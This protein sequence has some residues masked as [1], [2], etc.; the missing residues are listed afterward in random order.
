M[1]NKEKTAVRDSYASNVDQFLNRIMVLHV[2][3]QNRIFD[4]FYERYLKAVEA[5][6][7]QGAFDFGMEEIR[8]RNLRRVA[9]GETLFVDPAS[10]ARTM[11]HELEGEVDVVRHT[12]AAA[13]SAGDQ[14][15]FRNKRSRRIYTVSK[16]WDAHRPE[17]FLTAVK[18]PRRTLEHPELEQKYER[19]EPVEAREWWEAEHAST[20]ATEPR[21]FYI[22]SGAI[23]PIYDKVMGSS[24]IQ[25]VKIARAVLADGQALVGLNL[26]AS[27]VPNVKQR[28]GIGTPLGEAS[29]AEIVDL[30]IGGAVIELDNGWQ[31]TSAGIAGDEV[32]ELVLNGVSGN[33][34]E[35]RRYHRG[36]AEGT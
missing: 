2:E 17:V 14:G 19:V 7:Q 23:F 36:A 20:P 1:L 26:S 31:L 29:P 15:F 12:F 3:K 18:G 16:H 10:G 9:E 22:L 6:K 32:V 33:R 4:L 35:L 8:A 5:A 34:E 13:A 27:D 24:G 11:L 25:T 28:L 30:L 21:R